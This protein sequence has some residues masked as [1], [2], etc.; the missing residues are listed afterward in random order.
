VKTIEEINIG[1]AVI[2]RALWIGME[3]AVRDMVA[4]VH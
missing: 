1:H 4:L 3:Q 2:S